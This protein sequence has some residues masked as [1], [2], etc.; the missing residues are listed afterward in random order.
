MQIALG[1]KF[2]GPS[3]VVSC[4]CGKIRVRT[5]GL[6]SSVFAS[7]SNIDRRLNSSEYVEYAVFENS[8]LEITAPSTD[9]IGVSCGDGKTRYSCTSC[10]SRILLESSEFGNEATALNLIL[11]Q[12]IKQLPKGKGEK[13]KKNADC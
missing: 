5:V 7:H 13:K 9:L 1:S 11:F 6:P 10:W 4:G 3:E 8:Q 12:G 2:K